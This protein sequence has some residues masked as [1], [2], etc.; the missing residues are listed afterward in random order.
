[1]STGAGMTTGM[2]T[3]VTAGSAEF[4]RADRAVSAWPG[5][6]AV[7]AWWRGRPVL[8]DLLYTGMLVLLL[9]GLMGRKAVERPTWSMAAL[10]VAVLL[11]LVLR[12]RH[13]RAVFG[14]VVVLVAV[15]ALVARPMATDAALL[16]A[17]YTVAAQCDRRTALV[18]VGVVEAGAIIAVLRW[19]PPQGMVAGVV[20]L[21]G[22]ATAAFLLGVNI[23]TRRAY[24]ASLEDRAVRAERERDQQS[25]LAAAAERARI[26]REMHDIVAHN[27]SV[28]IALA[29]GAAFAAPHDSTAAA[30]AARQVSVTGRAALTEMQRLVSVLRG[31]GPDRPMAP[32][33]G[34]DQ[35]DDLVGQVR[36]AGLPTT[37]TVSGQRFPVPPTAELAVYRLVQEALT[38]VLKHAKDPTEAR[39]TLNYM[40]PAIILW[41]TDNGVGGPGPSLIGAGGHGLNGM[42]ERAAV[43]DGW[44]ETGPRPVGGWQVRALLRPG[45]VAT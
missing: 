45:R 12:R 19:V 38:N 44:V 32:Q 18:A 15:Q 43:F 34:I 10:D 26:A 33:P 6:G 40:E 39:V 20:F 23:R 28:M 5:L 27:L 35:L 7:R 25:R 16:V 36:A 42:R 24:L 1:M 13:P 3:E 21:T 41:V 37:F 8:A 4:A 17:L 30:S 2:T 29:D 9:G 22:M 14:V 11:P 31:D